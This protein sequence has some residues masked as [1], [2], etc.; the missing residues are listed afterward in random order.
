M[1]FGSRLFCRSVTYPVL[2]AIGFSTIDGAHA[3]HFPTEIETINDQ[4]ISSGFLKFFLYFRTLIYRR[5]S[6]YTIISSI[7]LPCDF[8]SS[9]IIMAYVFS[10]FF[11]RIFFLS[12]FVY[13][14][15]IGI[16]CICML[17]N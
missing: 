11:A 15:E 4:T 1:S 17:L 9:H 7:V 2:G 16:V 6:I 13:L 14:F 3:A 10:S 5:S 8:F 12:C